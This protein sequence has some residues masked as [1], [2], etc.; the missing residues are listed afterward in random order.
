MGTLYETSDFDPR[1]AYSR[2]EELFPI[3]TDRT[4]EGASGFW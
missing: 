4:A 2:G 1:S 3:V